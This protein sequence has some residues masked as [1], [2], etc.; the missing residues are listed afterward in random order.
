MNKCK[1]VVAWVGPCKQPCVEEFCDKHA[2]EICSGCGAHATHDCCHT[3]QFVCGAPLCENCT[4]LFDET[5]SSGAWGF[6]N[7]Y[8][9]PKP[10]RGDD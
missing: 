2:A 3:G 9:G 1:F 4:G 8:H 7:H 6:A 10:A 5:K